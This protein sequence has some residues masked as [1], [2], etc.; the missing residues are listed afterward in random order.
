MEPR[1]IERRAEI[2][3][4]LRAARWLAGGV[5]ENAKG[6]VDWKVAPLSA[7]DLA[8]RAPLVENEVTASLIGAIERMERPTKPMELA[9]L[10][11]ALRLPREWFPVG[12]AEAV[13]LSDADVRRAAEILAPQLLA[14]ARALRPDPEAGSAEPNGQDPL[15]APSEGDQR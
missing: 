2:A 4:R 13:S 3:R 11:E 15:G 12:S 7:A 8:L 9:A 14:A 1:D 10:A 6:K 5:V